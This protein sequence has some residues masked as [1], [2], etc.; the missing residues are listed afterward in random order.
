M[1]SIAGIRELGGWVGT[2]AARRVARMGTVRC[3]P[4][5]VVVFSLAAA[6]VGGASWRWREGRGWLVSTRLSGW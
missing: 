5:G 3:P 4:A 2:G 6:G 1:P